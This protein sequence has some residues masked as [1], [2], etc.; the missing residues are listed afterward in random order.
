MS[1]LSDNVRKHGAAYGLAIRHTRL[2]CTDEPDQAA[3]HPSK[4]AS[5]I[6]GTHVP[7][8]QPRAPTTAEPLLSQLSSPPHTAGAFNVVSTAADAQR[9]IEAIRTELRRRAEVRNL[10]LCMFSQLLVLSRSI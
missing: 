3:S 9:A 7:P 1:K 10:S 5:P 2:V 6:S 8:R 4:D